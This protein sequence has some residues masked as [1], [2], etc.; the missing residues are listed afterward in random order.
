MSR[1]ATLIDHLVKIGI[2]P[3]LCLC[4][5]FLIGG[6]KD[7]VRGRWPVLPRSQRWSESTEDI[8][9]FRQ[10]VKDGPMAVAPESRGMAL[11]GLSESSTTS[12]DQGSTRMT[13]K[14]HTSS[15]DDVG[16]SCVLAAGALG[17]Q[18]RRPR[19]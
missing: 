4:D 14:R 2:R 1:P 11:L 13:K 5:R 7:A 9:A 19:Q 8:S 18:L 10:L 12:D 15:R 6:L 17:R 3:A 16:V